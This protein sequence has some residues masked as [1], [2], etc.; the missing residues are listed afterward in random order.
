[1]DYVG[2]SNIFAFSESIPP[3]WE[4]ERKRMYETVG[5]PETD[6]EQLKATSPTFHADRIKAPLFIAQGKNDPRV[7]KAHS[8]AMV[9]AMRK[10]GVTVQYMVKDNEGH[11]FHNE[12]NRIDFYRAMDQFL[13]EHLKLDR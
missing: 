12:E 9:E 1:M 8:D 4:P 13:A 6:A 5:N 7:V 10:R 2:V 3:Y 11:G